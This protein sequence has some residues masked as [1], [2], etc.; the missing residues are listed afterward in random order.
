MS[1]VV[2]HVSVF[3]YINSTLQPCHP[4][5]NLVKSSRA[6]DMCVHK[7]FTVDLLRV[8]INLVKFGFLETILLHKGHRGL[9]RAQMSFTGVCVSQSGSS[10]GHNIVT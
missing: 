6:C 2:S 7:Q 4:M 8:R 9:L 5:H 10:T 3:F 1:A